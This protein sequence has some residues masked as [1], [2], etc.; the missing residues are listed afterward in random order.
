MRPTRRVWIPPHIL[1]CYRDSLSQDT[2]LA[3][4]HV[5]RRSDL[6]GGLGLGHCHAQHAT[7]TARHH[8]HV[9]AYR[10]TPST[11]VE[12]SQS[13]DETD[14]H[15]VDPPT[16]F[17]AQKQQFS[18][19]HAGKGGVESSCTA[20]RSQHCI[21]IQYPVTAGGVRFCL[22]CCQPE[23]MPRSLTARTSSLT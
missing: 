21:Q 2:L 18:T 4:M 7:E 3:K 1:A 6:L 14:P 12:A 19:R 10:N 13:H 20:Q 9:Y 22:L 8:E 5:R 11:A 23:P 16:I 17:G 15:V